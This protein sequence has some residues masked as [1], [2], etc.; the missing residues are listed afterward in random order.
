MVFAALICSAVFGQEVADGPAIHVKRIA[1]AKTISAQLFLDSRGVPAGF[2]ECGARHI[3]EHLLAVGT[4][5]KLDLELEAAGLTLT[6]NTLREA[7][8][9]EISG[10][11]AQWRLA[12]SRLLGLLSPRQWKDSDVAA[13][14]RTL[15]EELAL[16][17][18]DADVTNAAWK[19]AYPTISNP[20]G[21][22]EGWDKITD[23]Q[24]NLLHRGLTQSSRVVIVIAGD[25]DPFEC[26]SAVD[27]ELKLTAS[28]ADLGL[29][30]L[31]SKSASRTSKNF[32]ALAQGKWGSA[33]AAVRMC[34]ARAIATA[35]RQ[36][37]L[38]YT[39]SYERGLF[40]CVAGE[41]SAL[42]S[43]LETVASDPDGWASVGIASARSWLG[44]SLADPSGY[45]FL[46]GILLCGNR[47][48]DVQSMVN[49]L[50]R[51]QLSDVSALLESVAASGPGTVVK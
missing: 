45:A 36:M 17:P 23:A 22:V 3:Y 30:E 1:N 49:A 48:V 4:D 5:G 34:A 44:R 15:A 47:T 41:E 27:N 21:S 25:I 19:A 38:K 51:V 37:A 7:T 12:L 6:A 24:L 28:N 14:R 35:S 11:A 46:S 31:A 18:P 13:E 39:P 8:R 9:I 20:F 40:C 42:R 32:V 26:R 2:D 50:N 43:T 33:V 29:P 10:P 16:L